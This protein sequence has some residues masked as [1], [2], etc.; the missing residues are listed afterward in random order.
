VSGTDIVCLLQD[1]VEAIHDEQIAWH[2]GREG[3]RDAGLLA[4]AL[5]RPRN[6]AAYGDPDLTSLAASLGYGLARNHP[7][8]D[9][10]K[11]TAFVAVETFLLL[12]SAALVAADAECVLTMEGLAGGTIGEAEFGAWIRRNLQPARP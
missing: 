3:I 12:N 9:G 5:D 1:V 8:V 10:N 2:G 7:F 6:L 11:R 4:S